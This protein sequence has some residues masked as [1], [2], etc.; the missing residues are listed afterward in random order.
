MSD[1]DGDEPEEMDRAPARLS[2]EQIKEYARGLHDG[3]LFTNFHIPEEQALQMVP[4]IF[5]P[6]GM[7]ALS[8]YD[9]TKL[10]A[11]VEWLEEAGPRSVNGYPIFMSCTVIHREDWGKITDLYHKLIAAEKAVLNGS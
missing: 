1:S 9:H 4:S 10:G 7:G 3:R 11:I 8:S 6:I 2:D 5:M